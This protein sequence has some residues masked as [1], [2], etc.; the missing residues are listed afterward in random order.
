MQDYLS[1]RDDTGRLNALNGLISQCAAKVRVIRETYW[2]LAQ[3][4]RICATLL[5][6]STTHSNMCDLSPTFPIA[7]AR[8]NSAQRP[9]NGTKGNI[10]PLSSELAAHYISIS[11]RLVPR[12]SLIHSDVTHC[13]LLSYEQA[14]CSS[15]RIP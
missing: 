10:D 9:Y 1:A 4:I 3:L 11:M 15:C 7:S 12:K 2:P 6:V 8:S 13:Q 5:A 14:L